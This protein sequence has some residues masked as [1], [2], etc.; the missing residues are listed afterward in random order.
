MAKEA[1]P[2]LVWCAAAAALLAYTAGWF[3]PLWWLVGLVGVAAAFIAYF[4][5]DPERVIPA[6]EDVVVAPADG[7]ITRL[8]PVNPEDP[9]SP[10]LV[11]IFLSPLDVHINR[12]PIA[13]VIRE[14]LHRPGSFKSAL[15]EDASLV[16]EQLILTLEGERI[17]VTL[18]QIAGF[19]ARRCVLW[20]RAGDRVARGERIGLIKFSSRTDLI[21][22]PEVALCVRQGERV[23]GGTTIVGRIRPPAECIKVLRSDEAY[24]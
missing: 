5:R 7:L 24:V 22:P 9:A 6:E 1:Y 2:Y 20:K 10:W 11:S 13:G 17:T 21:V 15:R 19:I 4:F 16:N 12:A 14:T 3:P 18:K 23:V 8:A